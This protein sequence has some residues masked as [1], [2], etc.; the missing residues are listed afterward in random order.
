MGQS[1]TTGRFR[2]TVINLESV[3]RLLKAQFQIK[4]TTYQSG[5]KR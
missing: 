2:H 3:W 1:K 4:V 5:V